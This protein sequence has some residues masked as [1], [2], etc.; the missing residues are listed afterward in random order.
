M[1][2][3]INQ[4]Q[5]QKALRK[6]ATRELS[7]RT[8]GLFYNRICTGQF[9]LLGISD[10]NLPALRPNT[11][12]QC[13]ETILWQHGPNKHTKQCHPHAT[14]F[15][16]VK[17][18]HPYLSGVEGREGILVT[19]FNSDLVIRTF[20]NP[21]NHLLPPHPPFQ[22]TPLLRKAFQNAHQY[23]GQILGLVIFV[24]PA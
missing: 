17:R 9:P 24:L 1:G 18:H 7:E 6:D 10:N 4:L 8:R 5:S 21:A 12:C 2:W 19:S 23:N 11:P 16:Q 13:S 3:E 14:Y 15:H 22:K 20:K